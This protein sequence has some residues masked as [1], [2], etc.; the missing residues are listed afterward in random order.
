MS[1]QYSYFSERFADLLSEIDQSD[2]VDFLKV[3]NKL[4]QKMSE[5]HFCLMKEEIGEQLTDLQ[6]S[7]VVACNGERRPLVF[8][9]DRLYLHRNW[10]LE[11]ELARYIQQKLAIPS[12]VTEE[13]KESISKVT[14][15][16][17]SDETGQ[18]AK[19]VI[20]GSTRFFSVISGGPGTGKT[21]T[22][23]YALLLARM[24]AKNDIKIALAAPTGKAAA[25]LKTSIL[26]N[27]ETIK[28]KSDIPELVI[29]NIPTEVKTIH[30]L[31]EW[32]SGF[33]SFRHNESNPLEC[34]LLVVDE[35][36]MVGIPLLS[37][38]MAAL[39]KDC[40]VI[41]V[42]DHNQLSSV[43]AGAALAEICANLKDSDNMTVLK[44]VWRTDNQT[45]KDLSDSV[46]NGDGEA[47][48]NI[49]T[50]GKPGVTWKPVPS[51][52]NMLKD[53]EKMLGQTMDTY[54]KDIVSQQ[55]GFSKN[56]S[57]VEDIL[58]RFCILSGMR[59][60][61]LGTESLNALCKK[62][63][64]R[65]VGASEKET[66]FPGIPLLMTVNDY[67]KN[68]FN[69]DMGIV[70][71]SEND[72]LTAC[73]PDYERNEKDRKFSAT[74]LENV[75]LGYALTIHKSQGSEY[76]KVIVILPDLPEQSLGH[77][78]LTRE[79][80][81]TGITRAKKE[82]EVWCTENVFKQAVEKATARTSGLG[83]RLKTS[84]SGY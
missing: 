45:I 69:G 74:L 84:F 20:M 4:W 67:E 19:A 32:H 78:L 73:F 5:G 46:C 75:E 61:L 56:D 26:R 71:R 55:G 65:F 64:A 57:K 16:V 6:K 47:A 35:A 70:V 18:Q 80:L 11:T 49:L 60:S 50:S 7:S 59:E 9:G 14:S 83:Q 53:L 29:S 58:G 13:A 77:A 33:G 66:V 54:Y 44:K 10:F 38:L 40:K 25:R 34:D 52:K 79:L 82:I 21:T 15:L 36:S 48:W 22:V 2:S 1:E 17:S 76:G 72:T 30:R 42:G 31:L 28:A 41:L 68:L 43:E 81:Y 8:D 23:V 63:C 27:L 24:M 12:M 39:K 37:R 3:I 62:I 51:G